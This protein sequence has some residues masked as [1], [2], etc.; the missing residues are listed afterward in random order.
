MCGLGWRSLGHGVDLRGH[1]ERK[2]MAW[3][4]SADPGRST[5]RNVVALLALHAVLVSVTMSR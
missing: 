5:Q 3:A 2:R 1:L 4:S